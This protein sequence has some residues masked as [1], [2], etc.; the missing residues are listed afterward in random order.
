[1]SKISGRAQSTRENAIHYRES[2]SEL[3]QD[4]MNLILCNMIYSLAGTVVEL[5]ERVERYDKAFAQL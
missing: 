3:S 1:M 2:R 5:A 4:Q